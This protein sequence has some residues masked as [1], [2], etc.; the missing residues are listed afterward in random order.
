MLL[1]TAELSKTLVGVFLPGTQAGL[2]AGVPVLL[3]TL[4]KLRTGGVWAA[5]APWVFSWGAPGWSWAPLGALRAALGAVL[6]ALGPL[7]GP[8]G[9]RLG[10][11]W[12]SL[13]APF[14]ASWASVEGSLAKSRKPRNAS[15]V[16]HCLMFSRSR[17]LQHRSTFASTSLPGASGRPWR[18]LGASWSYLEA[19]WAPPWAVCVAP[20]PSLG[21]SRPVAT[22]RNSRNVSH[23][24][25]RNSLA[26]KS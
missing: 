20:G 9:A 5:W 3:L 26:V 6:G 24:K 1:S 11:I 18:L 21:D 12:A 13:G 16:Q 2:V 7:L 8:P 25:S 15:T 19:L 10:L 23:V 17:G 22:H 14:G 4:L